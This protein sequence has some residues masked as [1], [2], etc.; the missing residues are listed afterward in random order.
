MKSRAKG[1]HGEL[2]LSAE[3]R[4]H[5]F[6]ARRGQQF[7]GGIDS[8]DIVTDIPGL[9]IECKRVEAGNPYDWLDQAIRDAGVK[10]PVVM[11]RRNRRDWIAVMRLED[12]L[13]LIK[14]RMSLEEQW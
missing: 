14:A 6:A 8:P 13:Q 2:E 12:A 10:M 5:G 9:H 1:K 11:H 4:K 7:A 3:L